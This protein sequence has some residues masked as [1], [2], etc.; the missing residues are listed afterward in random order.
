MIEFIYKCDEKGIT[1]MIKDTFENL[2]AE[3]Q[4]KKLIIFGCGTYFQ[5][6]CNT[7]ICL[8]DKIEV[9]LDNYC[10]SKFY[11]L[12]KINKKIPILIPEEIK[13]WCMDN[14]V[15][16]FCCKDDE[17]RE[18]MVSQLDSLITGEYSKFFTPIYE[19]YDIYGRQNIK[20]FIIDYM[21]SLVENFN[22]HDQ[23]LQI[24]R[25]NSM[26]ELESEV[27]ARRKVIVPE[28]AV[29]LTS[30]CTLR[31]KNCEN[32]MWAFDKKVID[33]PREEICDSLTRILEAVDCIVTVC[34]VGG[35]PFLAESFPE[36]LQFLQEQEKV[37]S[38]NITT[39][40]TLPI[41]NTLIP[42]L[43]NKNLEI[44]IG[45]YGHIVEQTNFVESCIQN[46]IRY[47]RPQDDAWIDFGDTEKRN[48]DEDRL[49][50]QYESCMFSK[51]CRTLWGDSLFACSFAGSLEQ[52]GKISGI[53]LKISEC[54]DLR[55][56]ILDFLLTPN[57]LACDYCE[58]DFAN[59]RMVPIA[60]QF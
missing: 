57:I 4:N 35:E 51:R 13:D 45:N 26:S 33:V 8:L 20:N 18:A 10:N 59:L 43:Q 37:L 12:E 42:L 6:F 15:V 17:K 58:A 9:I 14:Y 47:S 2:N 1:F 41:R 39:N 16:L 23:I 24:C 48:C 55:N 44:V 25:C 50:F 54:S 30:R 46:N 27:Y 22:L 36:I 19:G 60:E 11:F 7:Y 31:C 53:S 52:L 32:L 29:I 28:L 49:R 40:G 5:R 21:I 56:A 3:L 38:I 34:V